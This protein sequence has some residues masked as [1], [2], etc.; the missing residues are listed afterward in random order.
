MVLEISA[1]CAFQI[2]PGAIREPAVIWICGT[3]EACH[4]GPWHAYKREAP[5][6]L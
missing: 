3:E 6:H 5:P 1:D 4:P 2:S